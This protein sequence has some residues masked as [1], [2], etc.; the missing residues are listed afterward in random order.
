MRDFSNMGALDVYY[1]HMDLEKMYQSF[2]QKD[3]L[4]DPAHSQMRKTMEKAITKN[5]EKAMD[6]LTENVNGHV[7]IISNSPLIVPFRELSNADEMAIDH[8][9]ASEFL[10]IALKKYRLS[11]PKDRR[12]LLDQYGIVDAARKVVGVGSVGMRAWIIVLE[13]DGDHDPLILQVKE[14]TS[15]V[16]E[17]YAGKSPY[18]EHGRRVIEGQHA[19]QTAGDILTGWVRIPDFNGHVMDYYVR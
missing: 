10:S 3:A 18:L 17:P 9:K 13:G 12:H 4:I 1:D 7:R 15:S 14:A 8:G 19:I 11:L 5:N 16:L 2:N 6:K